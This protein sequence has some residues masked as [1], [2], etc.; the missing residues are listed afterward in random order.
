MQLL[1][2]L[3]LEDVIVTGDAAFTYQ[4][5]DRAILERGGHYFPAR[6]FRTK[7]TYSNVGAGAPVRAFLRRAPDE[8]QIRDAGGARFSHRTPPRHLQR[9]R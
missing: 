5:I 4:K 1:K 7:T 2:S 8:S 9:G 6:R 3:P